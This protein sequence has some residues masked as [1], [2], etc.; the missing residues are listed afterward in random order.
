MA[1]VVRSATVKATPS[2]IWSIFGDMKWESWDPDLESVENIEG[3]FADGATATFVMKKE[4]GGMKFPIVITNFIPEK[5]F[6]F[7]GKAVGGLL[8][9]AGTFELEPKTDNETTVT[10]T[11]SMTGML[12]GLMTMFNSKAVVGGTEGGLANVVK[13]SEEASNK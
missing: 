8:K 2:K 1:P 11:Y 6:T 7:E 13:L 12:G 4:S 9:F 10:F 3:G 5:Q